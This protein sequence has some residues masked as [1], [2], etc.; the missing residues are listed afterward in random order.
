[1]IKDS[2]VVICTIGSNFYA[3]EEQDFEESNIFVPRNIAKQVAANPGVKRFIYI[4][5]AGA[6]PNSASQFLRTKW[7]G[8]QEVKKAC[9]DATIF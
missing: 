6:D 2:N 1:V 8:E 4:S 5:A 7:I 9:P 3:D